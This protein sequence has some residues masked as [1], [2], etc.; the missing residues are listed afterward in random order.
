MRSAP[1]R[2]IL[3]RSADVAR[4]TIITTSC[5][6]IASVSLLPSRAS[7]SMTRARLGSTLPRPCGGLWV[8]S[9]GRR[10]VPVSVD[11]CLQIGDH[12]LRSGHGI[13]A[14]DETARRRLLARNDDERSR[15]LGRVA[16][17]LAILGF[18]ELELLRSALV[19]VRDGRLGVV[20]RL[21]GEELSAEETRVDEGGGDAERRNLGVQ[22]RRP[23]LQAELR[24]GV[25]G[26][27]LE[28]DEARGRGDRDDVPR[29]L[30]AHH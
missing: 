26:T 21:L 10:E 5:P 23:A 11:L 3:G 8:E 6:A 27:E 9:E 16:G 14:G 13:G 19:V 4:R 20:R 15:E 1:R 25:G 2:P 7:P 22:R 18:P 29:A 28:A 12:L 17:L 30:L 24:R